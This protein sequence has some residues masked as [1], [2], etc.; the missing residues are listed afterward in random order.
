M[1]TRRTFL[2]T[3]ALAA[4]GSAFTARSWAQVAGANSDVRIAVVGLNGRGKDLVK[5]FSA[6]PGVRVVALCDVDSAVRDRAGAAYS[7]PTIEDFRDVLARPDVDAVG[8]STPN[9][10]HALQTIWACQAGK[11]VYVEKPISHE[12]W[13]GRQMIAA[14]RKYNRLG[15][16]GSQARSSP[17]IMEA[18][19]WVRAGNLGRITAVR[20][21]CYK[22]RASLGLTTAPTP[23]P[24]TVN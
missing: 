6:V 20:G 19:A 12:V 15:E 18:V 17:A 21:L 22:R 5:G 4:A 23:V 14:L 24:A 2:K 11:D 8:L 3:T 1:I 10:W 13:E 7:I 9:H 16:A